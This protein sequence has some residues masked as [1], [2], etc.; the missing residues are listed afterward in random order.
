MDI[1]SND[2]WYKFVIFF[3]QLLYL[4]RVLQPAELSDVADRG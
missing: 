1:D 2:A 3:L 4:A